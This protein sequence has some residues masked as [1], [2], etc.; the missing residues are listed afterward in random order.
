MPHE[1]NLSITEKNITFPNLVENKN[2]I[3]Y[4]LSIP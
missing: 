2:E 3:C 4:D 1:I